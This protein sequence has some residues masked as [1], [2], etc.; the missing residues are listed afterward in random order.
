M[1]NTK[2]VL[3]FLIE[4]A[5]SSLL[6]RRTLSCL[7]ELTYRCPARCSICS[8]WCRPTATAEELSLAEIHEGLRRIHR[9]GCR[10]VT[11]TGGEPTARADLADIIGEASRLRMWTSVVTNGALLTRERLAGLRRAGLSN[12]FVSLDSP[13]AAAHDAQRGLPGNHAQVLRCLRW[14]SEDFIGGHRSGGLFCAVTRDNEHAIADLA[15]IAEQYDVYAVFQLYHSKKTGDVA[16]Q[17]RAPAALADEILRLNRRGGRILSTPSF[18]RGLGRPPEQQRPCQAGRKY[19]SID[20]LGGLHPCVEMPRVG[21]VLKD[22]LRVLHDKPA[23]LAVSACA[24]CWYC[25]R[26]ESEGAA[27]GRGLIEKLGLAAS[28]LTHNLARRPAAKAQGLAD[29]IPDPTCSIEGDVS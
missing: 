12:L 10:V 5:T 20:P 1:R 24:G 15:R 25:F 22:D 28:I 17:P 2:D 11:F 16:L 8:Y 23:H 7:W 26:G 29:P 6:H 9:S 19:F 14:L 21:H 18:L 13:D 27:T 4:G 3:G